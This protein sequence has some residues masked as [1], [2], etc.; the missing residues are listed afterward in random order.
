MKKLV[1]ILLALAMILSLSIN[2][3]ADEN[4]Q[5]EYTLTINGTKGH[6]YKIYQI[7]TGKVEQEGD[8]TVLTNVLYGANF[9]PVDGQPGDE[10]PA[11]LLEDFSKAQDLSDTL[12]SSDLKGTPITVNEGRNESTVSITLV[13][14]YYMIV[15]VTADSVMP[16]GETKSPVILQVVESVTIASKHASITSEKK[17]ADRNDSTDAADAEL[18]WHDVADYDIGDMVPFQLSVTLPTTMPGYDNYTLTF[19][20]QQPAGLS[21]DITITD[22]YILTAAGVKIPVGP[23]VNGTPGYTLTNTCTPRT[24]YEVCEFEHC[25]FNIIVSDINAIYGENAYTD[26]DQLIIAYTSELLDEATTGRDGNINAMYVCHPDGHTPIDYVT[27]LTYELDITKIDGATGEDLLGAKFTLYKW[28]VADNEDGG[29][30][31]IVGQELDGTNTAKFIWRGLDG[32]RYLLKETDAPATYNDI[33]DIEFVIDATH[34]EDWIPDGGNRA[35]LDVIAKTPDGKEVVFAD[36]DANDIEDGI[37]T[38]NIANYK[39][40]ILPETGA[41][42]TFFLITAGTLLVMV[43]VV[44]MITR[45]KMSVYED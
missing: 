42:G 2:V 16:D 44:F 11:K 36:K 29:V 45:K 24:E 5:E 21:D 35:F 38:G 40:A 4:T 43:A 33:K 8:K 28:I 12:G 1:S 15:D 20:D 27:V 31:T 34:K 26:G 18:V 41:E 30:W 10:V 39:G 37:L 14:G 22:A 7:F 3:L 25:S 32:G 17:V 13:G 19:H 6:T 9:Y 23:S